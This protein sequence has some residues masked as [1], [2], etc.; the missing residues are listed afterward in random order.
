VIGDVE[1]Y[2]ITKDNIE[3]PDLDL[4]DDEQHASYKLLPPTF[5]TTF[6]K[7]WAPLEKFKASREQRRM[8]VPRPGTEP[9][10]I[11]RFHY[12]SKGW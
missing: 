10:E 2:Y 9:W 6:E 1:K 8:N 12:R 3:D 11:F 4:D 7:N 5:R